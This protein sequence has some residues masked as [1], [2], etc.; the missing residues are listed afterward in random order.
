[1]TKSNLKNQT[2]PLYLK[3]ALRFYELTEEKTNSEKKKAA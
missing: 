3:R 2:I 1:M